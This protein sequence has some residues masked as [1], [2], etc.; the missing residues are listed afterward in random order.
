MPLEQEL[1]TYGRELPRLVQGHE[2]EFVLIHGDQVDSFWP[3]EDA[4]YEAGCQRFGVQ[5]FL[6]KRVQKDEPT[7]PLVVDVTPLCPP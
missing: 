6:V 3:T 1:E 4:A 5:P 2:G 7:I